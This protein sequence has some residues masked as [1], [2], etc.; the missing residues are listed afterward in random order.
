MFNFLGTSYLDFLGL[1]FFRIL[2]GPYLLTVL[3]AKM[4]LG[5]GYSVWWPYWLDFLNFHKVKLVYIGTYTLTVS[6]NLLLIPWYATVSSHSIFFFSFLTFEFSTDKYFQYSSV[7]HLFYIDPLKFYL[8]RGKGK[9]EQKNIVF[10]V[11]FFISKIYVC[12]IY[13]IYTTLVF[14]QYNYSCKCNIN[15][16]L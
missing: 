11:I 8:R 15:K 2:W 3:D 7:N 5:F 4:P 16:F 9:S 10:Q 6:F 14:F 12:V 13:F 1:L